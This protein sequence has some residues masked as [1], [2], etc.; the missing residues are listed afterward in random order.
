MINKKQ[1]VPVIA[2]AL[3]LLV[4]VAPLVNDWYDGDDGVPLAGNH[5]IQDDMEFYIPIYNK[6]DLINFS[7]L[8]N[9]KATIPENANYNAKLM[10]NIVF[11]SADRD[12]NGGTNIGVSA[13]LIGDVLRI[14]IT[15]LD[16]GAIFDTTTLPRAFWAGSVA[17]FTVALG[18]KTATADIAASGGAPSPGA[19]MPYFIAGNVLRDGNNPFAYS[20][21]FDSIPTSFSSNGNFTPI[22]SST[23]PYMDVTETTYMRI[24]DG[25]KGIFEGNGYTIKD[26]NIIVSG[27]GSPY[28]VQ[29]GMFGILSPGSIVRNL[30]LVGGSTLA[31]GGT[32]SNADVATA[33]AIAGE[34]Y[35][36][37]LN[38]HTIGAIVMCAAEVADYMDAGG[39][40]GSIE[41]GAVVDSC[42]VT[43]L[44]SSDTGILGSVRAASI[45]LSKGGQAGAGGITSLCAGTLT[46]C[47]V[48]TMVSITMASV[49][50]A[51]GIV[52]EAA[53]GAIIR[54]CNNIMGVGYSV[55]AYGLTEATA[56]GVVGYVSS[57]GFVEIKQASNSSTV[58]AHSAS[59]T[60]WAGGIIGK[61]APGQTELYIIGSWNARG[62][63]T[64]SGAA[65]AYAGGIAGYLYGK[66]IE[67]Y[68]EGIV[69]AS[70]NV[71]TGDT[72]RAYAGGIAGVTAGD[73]TGVSSMRFSYGSSTITGEKLGLT[74]DATVFV[75]GIAGAVDNMVTDDGIH[76]ITNSFNTNSLKAINANIAVV[77]GIVGGMRISHVDDSGDQLYIQQ[78]Y[79][80]GGISTETIAGSQFVGG[81]IGHSAIK[82]LIENSYQSNGVTF[83]VVTPANQQRYVG[84]L[85]GY[86]AAPSKG[87]Q[88]IKNSY[89]YLL[90]VGTSTDGVSGT[91]PV[92]GYLAGYFNNGEIVE[93][94]FLND[95]S[96]KN[97]YAFGSNNSM[98]ID[99]NSSAGQTAGGKTTTWMQTI[100]DKDIPLAPSYRAN[101]WNIADSDNI[102][103]FIWA[104]NPDNEDDRELNEGF[105]VLVNSLFT[106][107]LK[108][109]APGVVVKIYTGTPGSLVETDDKGPYMASDVLYMEIYFDDG[110]LHMPPNVSII[111]N[112]NYEIVYDT[113]D[114]DDDDFKLEVNKTSRL[115]ME[116]PALDA[117]Y[118]EYSLWYALSVVSGEI[119]VSVKQFTATISFKDYSDA[120]LADAT[121][122]VSVENEFTDRD[123]KDSARTF[124]F[125]G[126]NN[127]I[128]LVAD[129]IP[130]SNYRFDGW[131]K[132]SKSGGSAIPLHPASG[133]DP[134]IV[135][136]TFSYREYDGV[137][138]VAKY[139]ILND[140]TFEINPDEAY[141]TTFKYTDF[142]SKPQSINAPRGYPMVGVDMAN[143]VPLK[144]V[145]VMWATQE[146]DIELTPMQGQLPTTSPQSHAGTYYRF[147]D[148]TETYASRV[149]PERDISGT[150][151]TATGINKLVYGTGPNPVPGNGTYMKANLI[152]MHQIDWGLTANSDPTS[153]FDVKTITNAYDLYGNVLTN[154]SGIKVGTKSYIENGESTSFTFEEN[155]D[156]YV[157]KVFAGADLDGMVEL[158]PVSGVYTLDSDPAGTGVE[159]NQY[160]RVEISPLVKVTIGATPSQVDP[161]F[162]MGVYA[163]PPGPTDL[164]YDL[165]TLGSG[166]DETKHL[167]ENDGLRLKFEQ[168]T[169]F[170]IKKIYWYYDSTPGTKTTLYD[171]SVDGSYV[172]TTIYNLS[173]VTKD[174][175]IVV[176]TSPGTVSWDDTD[177][178]FTLTGTKTAHAA[179]P[180]GDP[181]NDFSNILPEPGEIWPYQ[182]PFTFTITDT[183]GWRVSKIWY[184]IDGVQAGTIYDATTPGAY[185]FN[186]ALIFTSL[187]VVG[188]MYVHVDLVEA[189]T[190]TWDTAGDYEVTSPAYNWNNTGAS[191]TEG[192]FVSGKSKIDATLPFD[193]TLDTGSID[194]GIEEITYVMGSDSGYVYQ[195]KSVGQPESEEYSTV[196]EFHVSAKLELDAVVSEVYS[197]AWSGG[198]NITANLTPVSPSNIV[199][200]NRFFAGTMMEFTLLETQNWV[201][202]NV[203]VGGVDIPIKPDGT[204]DYTV[205]NNA[206]TLNITRVNAYNVTWEEDSDMFKLTGITG[207]IPRNSTSDP[208]TY[209]GKVPVASAMY[210]EIILDDSINTGVKSVTYTV[211]GSTTKI[212]VSKSGSGYAIP[213]N[214]ITTGDQ[215]E[216]FVEVV[217]LHRVYWTG[218]VEA[219]FTLTPKDP[220]TGYASGSLGILDETDFKFTITPGPP[221]RTVLVEYRVHALGTWTTIAPDVDG[222]NAYTLSN[223]TTDYDI[224]VRETFTLTFMGTG[225][226]SGTPPAKIVAAPGDTISIGINNLAKSPY[227]I[228]RWA[229][230]ADGTGDSYALGSQVMLAKTITLYPV[231]ALQITLNPNGGTWASGAN[232]SAARTVMVEIGKTYTPPFAADLNAPGNFDKTGWNTMAIPNGT[233]THYDFGDGITIPPTATNTITIYAEYMKSIIFSPN[234]GTWSDTTSTNKMISGYRNGSITVPAVSALAVRDPYSMTGWNTV[235]IPT[236]ATP[237][238]HINAGASIAINDALVKN[239]TRFAEWKITITFYANDA[240]VAGQ[241]GTFVEVTGFHGASI[242]TPANLRGTALGSFTFTGWNANPGAPISLTRLAASTSITLDDTV[243]ETYYAEWYI[244]IDFMSNNGV[245]SQDVQITGYRGQSAT[246]PSGQTAPGSF[247]MTGWNQNA[248]ADSAVRIDIGAIVLDDAKITKYYAE[249]FMNVNLNLNNPDS[250]TYPAFKGVYLGQTLNLIDLGIATKGNLTITRWDSVLAG[251]G[252]SYSH[253]SFVVSTTMN[254]TIYAIWELVVAF[255]PNGGTGAIQY[256]TLEEGKPINFATLT[257]PTAPGNYTHSGWNVK[258]VPDGTPTDH[259]DLDYSGIASSTTPTVLYA[260][261]K[262]TMTFKSNNGATS[263]DKTVT[264]YRG[265]TG[266][267]APNASA[268]LVPGNYS[269]SGWNKDAIYADATNRFNVSGPIT[270]DNTVLTTYNAEWQITMTFKS[271][272]GVTSQDKTVVAYRN[273]TGIT[274]PDASGITV[275]G[276]YTIKGWNK[277]AVYA[278]A[279]VRFNLSASI[280]MDDTVLTT[281]NA[282]WQ[283]IITFDANGG[284]G[285]F[286]KEMYLGQGVTEAMYAGLENNP[287]SV[288]SWN[289]LSDETGTNYGSEFILP[290]TMDDYIFAVWKLYIDF[291]SNEGGAA[292]QRVLVSYGIPLDLS[293][294]NSP[295]SVGSYTFSGWNTMSIP[296]GTGIHIG[297][298]GMLPID[299]NTPLKFYAEWKMDIQFVSNGGVWNDGTPNPLVISGYYKGTITTPVVGRLNAPG[300]FNMSGWNTAATPTAATVAAGHVDAGASIPMTIDMVPTTY[301]AEWRIKILFDVNGGDWTLGGNTPLEIWGYRLG[302]V[303]TP[304]VGSVVAP[305][306]YAL[307]GWNKNAV[308]ANADERFNPNVAISIE[309]T[310]VSKTYYAEWKITMTFKSNN[311]ETTEDKTV[312]A[313]RGQTGITAP[314]GTGITV[315][316]NYSLSGWNKDAIYADATNRFNV[317]GPIV[318][319]NTVQ[320]TY[321]AE[322]KIKII[323]EHNSGVMPDKMVDAYRGQTGITA[324]NANGML[325]PGNYSMSGWNKDAIYADATNRFNVSGPITMDDSVQLFYYAE[326]KITMT[327]K[328]NN[329]ETTEDKMVTAYRNQT[330]I[331]A[332]NGTGITVPGNYSLV[333]WNKDTIYADATNRFN[334]SGP[335]T[336]D[337]TI[338]LIYHG[339]WLMT[340]TLGVNGGSGT[341]PATM[342]AYLWQTVKPTDLG[343]LTLAGYLLVGWSVDGTE[344]DMYGVSFD[345]SLT[346]EGAL[347][348]VWVINEY[349][350]TID[351]GANGNSDPYEGGNIVRQYGDSIS[352]KLGSNDGYRMKELWIN[353]ENILAGVQD[354]T[355]EYTYVIDFIKSDYAIEIVTVKVWIVVVE[356]GEGATV[357]GQANSANPNNGVFNDVDSYGQTVVYVDDGTIVDFIVT[358]TKGNKIV[359]IIVNGEMISVDQLAGNNK[360][361]WIYTTEVPVNSDIS[362]IVDF[363]RAAEE[364]MLPLGLI[365]ITIT[366]VIAAWY[367]KADEEDTV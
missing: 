359:D 328:S 253:Q 58:T 65:A 357:S 195:Y 188:D 63:I 5:G 156:Y 21:A 141:I 60:A 315:P 349:T 352:I 149:T 92:A 142:K 102:E 14:T 29:A 100:V 351:I 344:T 203:K 39:I 177:S 154:P 216:I 293:T 320:L 333:G 19:D 43:R 189:Y 248:A 193:F 256:M 361:G 298:T 172:Y 183:D 52:A 175:T 127:E 144:I 50:V 126:Q 278:N 238:A 26:M 301:N 350:I 27:F 146:L 239:T 147:D 98:I 246:T 347:F 224:R 310:T 296:N 269:L 84:G 32:G 124:S 110:T 82:F 311:G 268:M 254:T 93:S 303:S 137:E 275:P 118:E 49:S 109:F 196:T 125:W 257:S 75:G 121:G 108:P 71:P 191:W 178:R 335:I 358:P 91:T 199:S 170:E 148:W 47:T 112:P 273:Q 132:M 129:E 348:A 152:E 143:P 305:G 133:D 283:I 319:N 210:F 263:Q 173:V 25:Y 187:P 151:N 2:V 228:V 308:Y 168:R 86:G 6:Y 163:T 302:T 355:W 334:V 231:W 83:A 252:T 251:T 24:N 244:A 321:N 241:Y 128:T 346:M 217:P 10:D 18:D 289:S 337:D 153:E 331:T 174:I 292:D 69:V 266:I 207:F 340:I 309:D 314:N 182:V 57:E 4:A 99:K 68:S 16:S 13:V 232:P 17:N 8:V 41:K 362:F 70:V 223:V 281:Y 103:G 80:E 122:K 304:A 45:G 113:D 220:Y 185:T 299:V 184:T 339:E 356:A 138:F 161:A 341:L 33:G 276:S 271:N 89:S 20:A 194:Y 135:K 169:T 179:D 120:T 97:A 117:P 212:P 247:N 198:T 167:I 259:F 249:W 274:A 56:G 131:F 236:T 116:Y 162:K 9:T 270:M 294:L 114:Y 15:A 64:A 225:A 106:I 245:G 366:A 258:M 11:T 312:T 272:N 197:V 243:V 77:G 233:G 95:G 353:G 290:L 330:G 280:T 164:Y 165:I 218:L 96:A 364:W 81:I 318:M 200:G 316:G 295:G 62:A 30:T 219:G 22:G 94:Y 3:M 180:S 90:T 261:W 363:M 85:V 46:G 322:W 267:T 317:S 204:L 327:F 38:C 104:I 307:D 326:W 360:D 284:T 237:G 324:P 206:S 119:D 130:S 354:I 222:G 255:H 342:D 288:Y 66:I 365:L 242:T 367:Y 101:G 51:G 306:N 55:N 61:S 155:E 115:L 42:S 190:V 205:P 300:N 73:I 105:P 28:D 159:E 145:A 111:T 227:Q 230:N 338:Q 107:N 332:P 74:G 88:K 40:C 31:F 250:S 157:T 234:G 235:S 44:Q 336:M 37:I 35:G 240:T 286:T 262:I 67:G 136:Y 229:E 171:E 265:Q 12:L 72:G 166:A 313:Y 285:T 323:F 282:E 139:T 325:A 123:L 297:I 87:D 208:L 54:D 36:S 53:D 181:G 277:D 287:F 226:S 150:T 329:G 343:T 209:S 221:S 211:N 1:I 158:N 202:T 186:T 23:K 76:H 160:I 59:D 279:T 79:N 140:V 291:Y 34:N 78:C 48:G 7:N 201:I 264:A 213:A 260:E 215:I 192:T 134:N 345:M 214:S 176:E